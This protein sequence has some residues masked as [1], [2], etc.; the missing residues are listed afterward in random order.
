MQHMP[1]RAGTR[2]II[3][4]H[5]HWQGGKLWGFEGTAMHNFRGDPLGLLYECVEFPWL[6]K[7]VYLPARCVCPVYNDCEICGYAAWS[8]VNRGTEDRPDYHH[9]CAWHQGENQ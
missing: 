8:N 2:V 4:D 7:L 9:Y 1:I 5:P 6:K 3:L